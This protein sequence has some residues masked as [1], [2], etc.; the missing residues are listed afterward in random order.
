MKKIAALTFAFATLATSAHADQPR[1]PKW[2]AGLHGSVPFVTEKDLE[3]NNTNLGGLAFDSGWGAGA[4]LGYMPSGDGA[5]AW[6]AFRIELEFHHQENNV[7]SL[8]S[9]PG[10]LNGTMSVDAYMANMFFDI[11]NATRLTPYVGVGA[12]WANIELNA[13]LAGVNGDD[14]V[15]A[16]QALAGVYYE[17]ELIPL[18]RWGVGYRYFDSVDPEFGQGAAASKVN[19]QSHSVEVGAQFRF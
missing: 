17:P 18:T 2:Y 5:S 4:S 12:G 9:L 19:Y 7:D 3:R 10:L 13:P 16:Y 8:A 14:T 11:K 6:D 15:I 1:W